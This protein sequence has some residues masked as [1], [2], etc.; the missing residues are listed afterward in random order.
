[1]THTKWMSAIFAAVVFAVGLSCSTAHAQQS[2]RTF[3]LAR[4]GTSD[5][6]DVGMKDSSG[7]VPLFTRPFQRMYLDIKPSQACRVAISVKLC[8]DSLGGQGASA[9]DSSKCSTW[10][11][12]QELDIA[13]TGDSAVARP[14]A[15]LPTS[16][17][18]GSDEFIIEFN[19]AG[20][21]KWN[22]PRGYTLP[23]KRMAGDGAWCTAEKVVIGWRVLSAAGVVTFTNRLRCYAW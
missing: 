19:A 23:L 7:T 14:R 16:V 15:T 12:G 4:G 8:G 18:G 17:Q 3:L 11:W 20:V 5:T 13:T 10:N 9:Q 22:N 21:A 2:F 6:T 1:M